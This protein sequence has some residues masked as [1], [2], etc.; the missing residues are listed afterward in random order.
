L[1][2]FYTNTYKSYTDSSL[3]LDRILDGE[4]QVY[5]G[6]N[7]GSPAIRIGNNTNKCY[8]LV[9]FIEKENKLDQRRN[10]MGRFASLILFFVG[11]TLKFIMGHCPIINLQWYKPIKLSQ[12]SDNLD[13][14]SELCQ[15][16][17]L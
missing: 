17:D 14:I 7:K 1:K 16:C 5:I 15:K 3:L 11:N 10:K 6:I 13:K 8:K 2:L 12:L 4:N 9:N